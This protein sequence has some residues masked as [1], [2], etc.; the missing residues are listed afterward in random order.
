VLPADVADQEQVQAAAAEVEQKLGP[1]DVW[2]NDAMVTV[3]SEFVDV[4]PAEFKRAT[5]VTY[6]GTVWGTMAA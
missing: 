2:V 4:S 5:E 1:I 3:F 6:L